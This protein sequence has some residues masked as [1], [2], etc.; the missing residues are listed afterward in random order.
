LLS[1]CFFQQKKIIF[2]TS[3][4][5]FLSMLSTMPITQQI[6]C[7]VLFFV[8]FHYLVRDQLNP[9]SLMLGN[10][11]S[12]IVGY[13][14]VALVDWR[15]PSTE[16]PAADAAYVASMRASERKRASSSATVDSSEGSPNSSRSWSKAPS[17]VDVLPPCVDG[18]WTP[19]L[20]ACPTIVRSIGA[21]LFRFWSLCQRV[22]IFCAVLHMSAP[23]LRT[24]TLAFSE[25]TIAGT[26]WFR[27]QS[28]FFIMSVTCC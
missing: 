23:V 15:K 1:A 26:H 18:G 24:L 3:L 16:A 17:T 22:I 14:V 28:L 8:V 27:I 2:Q 20:N 5:T 19:V 11:V 21:P 6:S 10:L 12:L 9:P 25:D 13:V 7:T 4:F